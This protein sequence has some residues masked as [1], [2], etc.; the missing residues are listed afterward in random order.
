MERRKAWAVGYMDVQ[1]HMGIRQLKLYRTSY[2]DT[3][4]ISYVCLMCEKEAVVIK[5][6]M[7]KT[8]GALL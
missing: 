4:P 8:S 7:T 1:G 5:M 6:R 2:C 3:C